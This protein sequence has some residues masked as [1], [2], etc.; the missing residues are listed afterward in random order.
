MANAGKVTIEG[1]N[2]AI[3]VAIVR[4]NASQATVAK[5]KAVFATWVL[6]V[7]LAALI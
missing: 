1:K 7:F 6:M 4:L 3:E 2:V 5:A